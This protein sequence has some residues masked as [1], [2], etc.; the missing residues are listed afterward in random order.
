ME[1]NSNYG[2]HPNRQTHYWKLDGR[3]RHSQY[4]GS[5]QDATVLPP[6]ARLEPVGLGPRGYRWCGRPW[7]STGSLDVLASHGIDNG[8]DS[9]EAEAGEVT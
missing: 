2:H 7:S 9:A 4:W 5:D 1:N 3:F 6:R 8:T